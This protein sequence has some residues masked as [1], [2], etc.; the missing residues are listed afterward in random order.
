MDPH[1][2]P[3]FINLSTCL[4]I[5]PSIYAHTYISIQ[6]KGFIQVHTPV[7]TSNDCEGAGE[8]FQVFVS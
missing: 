3:F 5:I 6:S 4:F 1:I 2:H 7:L 8:L